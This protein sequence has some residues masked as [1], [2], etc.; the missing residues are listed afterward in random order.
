MM[1]VTCLRSRSGVP[2]DE[3]RE[4]A[5]AHVVDRSM[6]SPSTQML[7]RA[8]PWHLAGGCRSGRG[9]RRR[10]DR[11]SR[12]ARD[13]LLLL[14]HLLLDGVSASR[15]ARA[16]GT[17]VVLAPSL[18]RLAALG[19][20]VLLPLFAAPP[21][22]AQQ[23]APDGTPRRARSGLAFRRPTR[24]AHRSSPGNPAEFATRRGR[25]RRVDPSLLSG[26]LL[27]LPLVALLLLR[28]LPL[29]RIRV[30]LRADTCAQREGQSPA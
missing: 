29:V 15:Q 20:G 1:M 6:C 3:Q 30:H 27:T 7:G 19:S 21:D 22:R 9:P 17:V 16:V 13:L 23:P 18:L 11:G 24:S 10:Q 14:D 5:A 28:A 8:G 25:L 2:L 12:S 26:P 4:R